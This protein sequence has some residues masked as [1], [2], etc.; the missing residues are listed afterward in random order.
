MS[1]SFV[2]LIIKNEN[3]H[4]DTNIYENESNDNE[5]GQKEDVDALVQQQEEVREPSERD[6][7]N[8]LVK[9]NHIND[10]N[11]GFQNNFVM[12]EHDT[13]DMNENEMIDRPN[14]NGAKESAKDFKVLLIVKNQWDFA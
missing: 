2:C 13:D 6:P 11:K 8:Y 12:P 10:M 7:H 3:Q 5:K 1:L 4:Q 14:I 9:P